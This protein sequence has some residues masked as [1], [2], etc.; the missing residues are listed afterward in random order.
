MKD[1]GGPMASDGGVG[2]TA[3]W[4]PQGQGAVHEICLVRDIKRLCLWAGPSA[5]ALPRRG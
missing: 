2:G 4:G 1:E 3:L 5:W